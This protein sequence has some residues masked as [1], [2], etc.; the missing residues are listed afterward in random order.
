LILELLNF[1]RPEDAENVVPVGERAPI[2]ALT[3]Q[4]YLLHSEAEAGKNSIQSIPDYIEDAVVF[5][6]NAIEETN[7][8]LVPQHGLLGVVSGK[9]QES[10]AN[11]SDQ[12]ARVFL[13]TNIPFS[14]MICG[15]Q[16]S[17]KSHSMSCILGMTRIAA[18]DCID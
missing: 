13:N 18:I 3:S 12:D 7:G 17:G 6:A 14:V 10:T 5:S 8:G 2:P 4:A 1:L 11:Q 9:Q 16:G 15:L